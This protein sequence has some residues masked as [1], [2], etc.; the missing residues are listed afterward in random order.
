MLDALNPDSLS[1][2]DTRTSEAQE[3]QDSQLQSK[4][5]PTNMPGM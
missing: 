1:G 2:L 3:D 5:K 4:T